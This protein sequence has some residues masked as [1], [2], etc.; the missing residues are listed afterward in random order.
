M[1][2]E[3][4]PIKTYQLDFFKPE[5]NPCLAILRK[6]NLE[7]LKELYNL[8][9]LEVTIH[10]LTNLVLKIFE[11]QLNKC[12]EAVCRKE[13]FKLVFLTKDLKIKFVDSNL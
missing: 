10:L 8:D 2:K 13:G 11:E 5:I 6:Y 4:N 9:F 3:S 12:K 1:N 7:N